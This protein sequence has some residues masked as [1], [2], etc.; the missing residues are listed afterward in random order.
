MGETRRCGEWVEI[1]AANLLTACDPC[2]TTH[3]TSEY[4]AHY[5]MGGAKVTKERG[6]AV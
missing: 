6:R 2:K 1:E 3:T 4:P 5:A